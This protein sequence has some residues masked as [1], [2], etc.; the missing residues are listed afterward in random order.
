MRRLHWD[1]A[2]R[3]VN[4]PGHGLSAFL[5]RLSVFGMIIAVSLLLAA[6]SVMNGFERE[7]RVRI[8]NLVPHVTV[9]GFASEIDWAT[10]QADLEQL[11]SVTRLNRFTDID[12]F[13][14]TQG[15]AHVTRLI[16][17]DKGALVPYQ[18]RLRP[19]VDSL[20]VGELI[21]GAHL[22]R[23]LGATVGDRV[24]TL[25]STRGY[26]S[27]L[28]PTTLKVV[29]VLS[30]DTEIDHVFSMAGRGSVNIDESSQGSALALNLG[31]PLDA[32]KFA[33]YLRQM[34]PPAFWVTDWTVTQGN[35]YQAIQLSRQIVVLMLASLLI[36]AM[37][38][39]VSS[40]VLVVSDRRAPSSMLRAIGLTSTDIAQIFVIQ[41]TVIGVGGAVLGAGLGLLLAAVIP[42]LVQLI[43]LGTGSPFLDT[44]VYPLAYVPVDIRLEDFLLVPGVALVLSVASCALPAFAAAKLPITEGL[45]ESRRWSRL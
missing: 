13:F 21:I 20:G 17:A 10:V 25:F 36:I 30:S 3:Q 28:R 9:R 4:D 12:A 1:I 32:P 39:V 31:D 23:T 18:A 27:T 22:A 6:L 14:V 15:N 40:L 16:I 7:M 33:R 24:S 41:G 45:R 2:V 37:F 35:L 43:E 5:S 8:L 44:A 42:S 34:L 26:Q 19:E 29:S 11:T 38:N